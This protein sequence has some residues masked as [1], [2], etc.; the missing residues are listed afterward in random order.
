LTFDR[1]GARVER[2]ERPDQRTAA[3]RVGKRES[4]TDPAAAET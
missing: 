3:S 4:T 2:A 1:R